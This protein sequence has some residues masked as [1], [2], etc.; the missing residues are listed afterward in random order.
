M[1]HKPSINEKWKTDYASQLTLEVLNGKLFLFVIE[2]YL[3]IKKKIKVNFFFLFLK[4]K[5]C[6]R[7]DE[8]M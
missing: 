4:V 8:K 5:Y 6:R 2:F 7:G 3:A 1:E